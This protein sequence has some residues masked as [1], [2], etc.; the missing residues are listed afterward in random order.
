M[1]HVALIHLELRRYF[2]PP[3]ILSTRNLGTLKISWFL[4]KFFLEICLLLNQTFFFFNCLTYLFLFLLRESSNNS[5][6]RYQHWM[7]GWTNF[8]RGLS[9]WILSLPCRK[10]QRV[11]KIFLSKEKVVVALYQQIFLFPGWAMVPWY[12]IQHLPI[13][14][15]KS[16]R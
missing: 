8:H 13:N 9:T 14:L 6:N 12:P 15:I 16:L 4:L 5:Q 1:I 3:T 10:H 2:H 7:K 11:N